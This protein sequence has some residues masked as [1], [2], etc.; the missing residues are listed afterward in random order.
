MDSEIEILDNYDH[1]NIVGVFDFCEDEYNIYIALELVAQGDLA[2]NIKKI[3][4]SLINRS[5]AAIEAACANIIHQIILA[6]AFLHKQ[7]CMHRDLK[8][9]N[10]LLKY[11]RFDELATK[12]TCKV[13]DFGFAV[14]KEEYEQIRHSLGTAPYMAPEIIAAKPYD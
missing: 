11:E 7:N 6:I 9:A 12:I 3:K 13:T 10:V 5:T 14:K 1:P 8:P 4:S 2:K